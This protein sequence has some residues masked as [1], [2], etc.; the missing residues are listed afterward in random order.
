M[1]LDARI[2]AVPAKCQA[3]D[4][5]TVKAV[6][7]VSADLTRGPAAKTRAGGVA[8]FVAVMDGDRVVDEQD[9]GLDVRFPPNI[10]RVTATGK[11]ITLIF[12][13]TREKSAAAYNIYVGFRLSPE[14]LA[15][16]R[17]RGPR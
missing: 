10:D 7:A 3:G 12:P 16:N 13:V 6:L 5:G 8:Y 9:Y 15:Y 17:Q 4:P 11:E 14:E 1:V 2:T